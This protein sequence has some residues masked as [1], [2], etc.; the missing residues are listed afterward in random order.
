LNI[1]VGNYFQPFII[2][3]KS[4]ISYDKQRCLFD[5]DETPICYLE[6]SYLTNLL[7]DTSFETQKQF[8]ECFRKESVSKMYN[9]DDKYLL[10]VIG[11]PVEFNGV[12]FYRLIKLALEY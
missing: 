1:P 5:K 4:G 3:C 9:K 6:S 12:Y 8:N 7:L 10:F 11:K 2:L